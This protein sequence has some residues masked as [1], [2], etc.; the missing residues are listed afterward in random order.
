MFSICPRSLDPF[1]IL[2]SFALLFW[3]DGLIFNRT[4]GL[5]IDQG[6]HFILTLII[7]SKTY[8]HPV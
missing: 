4:Q 7:R 5:S 3:I 1:H 2:S 6:G 8:I